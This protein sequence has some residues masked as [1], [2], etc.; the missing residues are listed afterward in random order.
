MDPLLTELI[1]EVR[2]EATRWRRP[3]AAVLNGQGIAVVGEPS[4]HVYL[5]VADPG[6]ARQLV[7][8]GVEVRTASEQ[9]AT[10]LGGT[11]LIVGDAAPP[12][13]PAFY[14]MLESGPLPPGADYFE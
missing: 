12:E 2:Q 3:V 5:L 7:E 8:I 14:R 1:R 6:V 9:E 10:M 4:G 13:A 11:D